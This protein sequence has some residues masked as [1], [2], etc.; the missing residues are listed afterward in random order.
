MKQ[1]KD[2][3]ITW[4]LTTKAMTYHTSSLSMFYFICHGRCGSNFKSIIVK[5]IIQNSGLCTHYEIALRWRLHI[6][7]NERSIL[8][9]I[10]AGCQQ[11]LSHYLSQC[12]PRSSLSYGITR[13]HNFINSYLLQPLQE[14]SWKLIIGQASVAWL[15]WH[16]VHIIWVM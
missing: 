1:Y 5:H 2:V 6:L 4:Q 13:T 8:V 3:D 11:A 14:I 16:V 9:S 12:W 10:M 7:T 15:T